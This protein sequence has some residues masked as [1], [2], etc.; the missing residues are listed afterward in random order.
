MVKN[1]FVQHAFVILAYKKSPYLDGCIKS[2]LHQSVPIKVVIA[3]STPNKFITKIAKKYNLELIINRGPSGIGNDFGF[4][5]QA[6]QAELVTVAHQD[7]VYEPTYAETILAAY[8]KSPQASILVSDYYEI[9][10]KTKVHSNRNLKIKR[11]LIFPLR[12]RLLNGRKFFKRL[13]LRFGSAICCPA[14]TY[15]QKRMPRKLFSDSLTC[16]VDWY[17][18]EKLSKK[19]G[20]FVYCK[21]HLMGHRIHSDSETTKIIKAKIRTE[22]DLYMLKKFWPARFAKVINHFYKKA[23]E[24]NEI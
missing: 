22:E 12:F 2:V 13:S 8:K 14:V 20:K 16:N 17:A 3:T 15:I 19:P 21:R 4:A 11:V 7:D 5:L 18:Y 9:R 23:E 6:V 24:S 1:D 10:G